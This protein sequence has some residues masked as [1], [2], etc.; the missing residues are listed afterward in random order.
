MYRIRRF[1]VV[2]T[3]TIAA[4]MYVLVTLAFVFPI[5]IIVALAGPTSSSSLSAGPF[6]LGGLFAAAI[7]GLLGW[8][9]TAIACVF[10]NI[11]AGIVGGI[12]VEVETVIPAPP[13]PVWGPITSPPA[14]SPPSVSG[15]V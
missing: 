2:K 13:P 5:T 8:V 14:G 7:Y 6:L 3:A 9:F 12:Q 11:A 15:S 10:Y 4:V 1:G